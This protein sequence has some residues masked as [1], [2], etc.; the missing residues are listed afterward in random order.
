M[1]KEIKVKLLSR[2]S[3]NESSIWKKQCPGS[4]LKWG[5]CKFITDPYEKNYDWYVTRNDLPY[6]CKN[7]VSLSCDTSK[8]ILFTTEPSSITS[9]GK[10]FVN[11]FGYLLTSQ[12]E[13]VLPH[14]KAIRSPTGNVWHYGKS[15]DEI[16]NQNPPIKT[17]KISTVCSSKTMRHTEHAKRLEF[18]KKLHSDLTILDLY[19]KGHSFIKNKYEAINPYEFH[20][21]IENHCSKYHFTEK[22]TDAFLGYSI[23][24]YYG[25]KNI[26]D[27]F[28]EDSIILIDIHDY[29]SS[30]NKIQKIIDNEN[31]YKK[32]IESIIEAR[33]RVLKEYN[34]PYMLSTIIESEEKKGIQKN[35]KN[36]IYSRRLAR[37]KNPIEL[38][39]FLKWRIKNY[40]AK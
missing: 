24:I 40:L 32:R 28:P 23:P 34:L 5:N 22:I 16:L 19:G 4:D 15:Y 31:E 3:I 30:L 18:T 8:S 35:N 27:Y 33:N 37:A 38:I 2:E 7:K 10:K 26:Y 11:Q 1:N 36:T 25:C 39:N 17:K 14:K 12:E 6:I 20:L 21:A 9:Y 29:Q 13:E